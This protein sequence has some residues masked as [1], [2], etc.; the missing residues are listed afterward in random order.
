MQAYSLILNFTTAQRYYYLY[1]NKW[2]DNPDKHIIFNVL[3][4]VYSK[5][6]VVIHYLLTEMNGMT[7]LERSTQCNPGL[8]AVIGVD[9]N[10]RVVFGA[11]NIAA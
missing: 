1:F 10:I 6:S 5:P 7:A 3:L 2:S 11:G 8:I 9:G 4:F